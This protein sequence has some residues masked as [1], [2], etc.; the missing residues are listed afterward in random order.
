VYITGCARSG[1]KYL[2]EVLSAAGVSAT[3]ERLVMRASGGVVRFDAARAGSVEVSSDGVYRC[4]DLAGLPGMRAM[5]HVIRHPRP[6]VASL[7]GRGM[8]EQGWGERRCSEWP[9][10]AVESLSGIDR[11]LLYWIVVNRWLDARVGRD[12]VPVVR[13]RLEDP[14]AALEALCRLGG[15]KLDRERLREALATVPRDVNHRV[16]TPPVEYDWREHDPRLRE[17]AEEMVRGYG[18]QEPDEAR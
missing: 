13:F 12:E 17:V 18:L 6:V 2:A 14:A 1:T 15:L 9:A 7:V 8:W 4:A 3:H 10:L 5:G 11:S 16:E